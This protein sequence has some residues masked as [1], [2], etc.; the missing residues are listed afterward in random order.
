MVVEIRDYKYFPD[1]VTVRAGSTVKWVNLEKRTSHSV[2]FLGADGFE[3]ER[4]FPDESWQRRFT[5]PGEYPYRCGP[6]PEMRGRVIVE[7]GA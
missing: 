4:M 7:Q 1:T 3:S 5:T 2:L 6:H